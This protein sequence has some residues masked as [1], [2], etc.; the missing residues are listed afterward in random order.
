M[1]WIAFF[2]A[3]SVSLL[4]N[5]PLPPFVTMT[6][7]LAAIIGWGLLLLLV[8]TRLLSRP[9]LRTLQP[10]LLALA[11]VAAACVLSIGTGRLPSSPGIV[12]L[13]MIGLAACLALHGA[14][15]AEHGAMRSFVPFAGV[16]AGTGAASAAVAVVQI[17]AY[18]HIDNS[19]IALPLQPGRAAGN[20]GQ[21]NQFADTLLWALVALVP[22]A[23][24]LSAA[25]RHAG[26]ILAA[27]GLV[28]LFYLLGIVLTG[29]RTAMVALL[30]LAVWGLW[31]RQLER[32]ARVALVCSP[33][34]ALLMQWP[35]HA[36]L[37]HQGLELSA[38]TRDEGG[39]SS[40][41]TEIWRQALA[42][43]GDQPWLGA[44]WGQLNFE[45][46]LTPFANRQMGFVDN[47]H[48]LP[49]HLAVEIGIPAAL[50]VLGLLVW[51][52]ASAFRRAAR[53][54]GPTGVS[55]RTALVMVTIIGFHSMLEYP[56]WYG[57]LLLPTAWA[58]GFGTCAGARDEASDPQTAPVAATWRAWHVI[59]L[60]MVVIGGSAWLDY[61]NIVSLYQPTI[62]ALPFDERI[63]HAQ[64]SPL[65]SYQG[66]Y[67]ALTSLPPTPAM[68]PAFE[69]SAHV[70][71]NARLLYAWANVLEQQGQTDKARYLAARL[72]EFD[73]PGPKPWF[74]PCDDPAVKAKPFQ[75]LP[76]ERPVSW[77]DFK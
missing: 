49:L 30:I 10:L 19:F 9:A 56:L 17:V 15:A 58:W 55:A 1:R 51:A 75:C 68:L 48:D 31:D 67:V 11:V 32:H 13:G 40:F 4:L 33:I 2:F 20:I 43:I 41:R 44:G 73:L 26:K 6:N 70:F 12:Q 3:I 65:F 66:D 52:L 46:T 59:G 39:V 57:Y 16:L 71:L 64:E 27:L 28:A 25:S 47:A 45:W 35:V 60:M 8:P 76:P 38:L 50:L 53:V 74:A 69:R 42:M 23:Q 24:H 22:L 36:W 61:R 54:A 37:A 72:R 21:A 7:Q 5:E 18:R 34:V 62:N 77:H 63:R 29:S 14:S